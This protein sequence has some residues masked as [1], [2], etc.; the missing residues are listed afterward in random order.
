MRLS[1]REAKTLSLVGE[2]EILRRLMLLRLNRLEHSWASVFPQN[3]EGLDTSAIVSTGLHGSVGSG[4]TYALS[5]LL[6]QHVINGLT[7]FLAASELRIFDGIKKLAYEGP[8]LGISGAIDEMVRP[9]KGGLIFIDDVGRS[10][11]SEWLDMVFPELLDAVA[12]NKVSVFYTTN[13]AFEKHPDSRI[14]S[15][16]KGLCPTQRV[17]STAE[18]YR[19]KKVSTRIALLDYSAEITRLLEA[20]AI[21][22]SS[23][24]FIGDIKRDAFSRFLS[25]YPPPVKL[26][27]LNELLKANDED[28]PGT[29]VYSADG[30]DASEPLDTWEI[31]TGFSP[32]IILNDNC[33]YSF[34]SRLLKKYQT[35]IP[36]QHFILTN[37]TESDARYGWARAVLSSPSVIPVFLE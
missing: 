21:A 14:Y 4:K 35:E 23:F 28:S 22:N 20:P 9:L 2:S 6:R 10:K 18:D 26:I 36:G 15:R 7:N 19:E 27:E 34:R 37:V 12:D 17:L 1:A 11:D 32:L 31:L 13:T 8:K 33:D 16:F 25:K 30:M 5:A 29:V 24:V 3:L